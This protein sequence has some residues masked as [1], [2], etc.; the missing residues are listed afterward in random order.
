MS[1]LIFIIVRSTINSLKELLKKPG[2]LIL[3][4]FLVLLI[5]GVAITSLFTKS[6]VE[7]QAPL[8]I[9][10]GILFAFISMFM[11]IAVVKGLSSGDNIFEMNDVNLLFVSPISPR[12][13]LLY[14]ILR[15]TKVAFLAGFFI[16]FQ[17]SSLSAFGVTFSG[18]ILILLSF[19]LD[20]VVLSI[21]S[22]IIYNFANGNPKKQFIVKIVTC[23]V[24]L[25]IVIYLLIQIIST[26][27]IFIALENSIKS[28]IMSIIPI[29]GWTSA[30][31]T[32]IFSGEPIQGFLFIGINLLLG[33]TLV[34]YILLSKIDYYED[35]LVATETAFE[36]KR[37]I[38]E[39]NINAASNSKKNIKI[40]KTGISGFGAS[41][42][43]GKHI[44]EDFRQNRFGLLPTSSILTIVASIIGNYF[45]K[46][47]IM[48][49]QVLMWL[50]V[51]MIGISRGLKETYSHYIYL[52]PESSVKK[53]IWSNIEILLKTLLESLL[54]F[55]IGG[56]LVKTNIFI[57]IGTIATYTLFSYLLLAINYV[58]MRFA[59]ANI[60]GGLLITIY[61][62]AVILI[63][64]PG[65]II[66]LIVGFGVGGL[67]GT[68]LGL[69]IL[70]L[71]EL[72]AGTICFILS[73]GILD[74]CDMPSMKLKS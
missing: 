45:V 1:S 34:I 28:P 51:F 42:I 57:I 73:K 11:I 40:A 53:I 47:L 55:G 7:T 72:I 29:S 65:V 68:L 58:S 39:G 60:T 19:M 4:V 17:S 69:L 27:N 31:I 8:F 13:I 67:L 33:I 14:G 16:L 48:F 61:Y 43:L 63:I 56:I 9:L 24:F 26:Q 59:E 52:I 46:D 5:I 22:L 49:M 37:A 35:A 6:K 23:L 70:S 74:N 3:Y 44:R 54:I 12:K 36:K 15:L 32:R 20:M 2:K 25:P 21:I 62:F 18:V 38:S 50:Q 64:A 41:A 66:A 30:G 10:T 71:W